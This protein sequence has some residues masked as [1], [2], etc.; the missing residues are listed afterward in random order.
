M[1]TPSAA[2]TSFAGPRPTPVPLVPVVPQLPH[3]NYSNYCTAGLYQSRLRSPRP[4]SC[5]A[6]ITDLN[7]RSV[8]LPKAKLSAVSVNTPNQVCCSMSSV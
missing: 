1:V 7:S 3:A 5:I 4:L 2:A 6:G 8:E